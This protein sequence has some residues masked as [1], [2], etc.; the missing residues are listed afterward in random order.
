MDVSTQYANICADAAKSGDGG[1]P[2]FDVDPVAE[3]K[4]YGIYTGPTIVKQVAKKFADAGWLV[5]NIGTERVYVITD[6]GV[7]E[8]LAFLGPTWKNRD[9]QELPR[10]K[11]DDAANKA[12]MDKEEAMKQRR[13]K[14]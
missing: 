4:K 3:D 2:S 5:S 12:T 1:A 7:D 11:E 8:I 10:R 14:C 6:K 13:G 9:I